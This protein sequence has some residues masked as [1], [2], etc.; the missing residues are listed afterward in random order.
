MSIQSMTPPPQVEESPPQPVRIQVGIDAAITAN[1]HVCIRSVAANGKANSVR[2][3]VPPTLAG[4]AR[5]TSRLSE[6]PGVV[7]VA[8]PTS[9]TWLSLAVALEAS[10]GELALIGARHSARLRGAIM[11]KNKSDV[12]DADVLAR[13]ADVFDLPPFEIPTPDQI[14]LRA[15]VT[16][17]GS[18]VM[19]T[20]RSFRRLLSLARW[21][22][23][24]VWEAFASSTP[25]AKAVL[26][27]WPNLEAL[28]TCKR[29]ALTA[30]VAEHTRGVTDVPARTERIRSA[31][32]GWS[33]FWDGHLN[34]DDL[35]W[36]VSEK[37]A[38][39]AD[40]DRRVA[41]A[42]EHATL[43]WEN[44]Y[45]EDP[46]LLSVP[47]VGPVTAPIIRAYLGDGHR[48]SCGQQCAS[49]AG[50]TPSTWSSGT[51]RQPRRAIT[52]EGPAILRL[53]L[54]Q[55]A[56]AARRV[57]P[58]FAAFYQRLMTKRGYCH[59]QA[60]VAVARKLAERI[61]VVLT[62]GRPYELRDPAGQPITRRAA[63]QLIHDDLTVDKNTRARTRSHNRATSRSKLTK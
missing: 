54:F 58:Q 53:A 41:R 62:E 38:D 26:E 4:L 1:H 24:D 5:L 60:T 23:P 50:L 20:N 29:P 37:L 47:G 22:F 48:F 13:S 43:C 49:Y 11:G 25:T 36:D 10:G 8:E 55:S 14:S 51:V 57:D 33:Q 35:A 12:I 46:L 16:R 15:A 9:M 21:A 42:T 3:Q 61:W 40:A 17:R 18:A 30:V 52:K 63:K 45:G 32:K 27:R 19:D 34:L 6:Y 44:I 2:F 31:A 56:N 39:L 7:A 28:A 59:S